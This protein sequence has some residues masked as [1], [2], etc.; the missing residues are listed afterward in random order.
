[1]YLRVCTQLRRVSLS[2]RLKKKFKNF[3]KTDL[4]LCK[5]DNYLFHSNSNI[6]IHN[7]FLTFKKDK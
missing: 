1:M 6:V 7:Q 4:N 3:I 5:T 2:D